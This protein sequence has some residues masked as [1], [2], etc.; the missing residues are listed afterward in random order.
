MYKE[1]PSWFVYILRCSDSSLYTGITTNIKQRLHEHNHSAKG[2]KYTRS[3]RP[4]NMAYHEKL[5]SRS[6]ASQREHQIKQMKK[7]EKEQMV[8]DFTG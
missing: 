5:S 7:S 1:K 4:V 2:A 6:E 8:N 3:R